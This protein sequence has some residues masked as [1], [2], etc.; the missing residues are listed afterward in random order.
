[1]HYSTS[2]NPYNRIVNISQ[3]CNDNYS[4]IENGNNSA[5]GDY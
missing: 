2:S 5:I 3:K 4:N 1:M